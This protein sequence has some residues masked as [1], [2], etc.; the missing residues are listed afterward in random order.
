MSFLKKLIGRGSEPE[1]EL[2]DGP[3]DHRRARRDGAYKVVTVIYPT[4][5]E[6]KGVAVDMSATGVRVRFSQR[7]ELPSRVELKIDG[8]SGKRTADV[9]WQETHDAGFK[10][11][12]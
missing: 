8:M 6:R 1:P 3:V 5:Y 10:F 9:V 12:G 4:G 2:D 11:V 7:G